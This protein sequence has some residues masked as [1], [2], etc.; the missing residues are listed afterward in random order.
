[1]VNRLRTLAYGK[2]FSAERH[3]RIFVGEDPDSWNRCG[4]ESRRGYSDLL[5]LPVGE[6]P[7][8]FHWPVRHLDV[9]VFNTREAININRLEIIIFACLNA[10]ASLVVA[11]TPDDILVARP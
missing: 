10:G 5:L 9:L 11:L 1:M 3:C 4:A 7:F 6:D 2:S 8:S